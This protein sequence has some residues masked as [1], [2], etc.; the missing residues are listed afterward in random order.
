MAY[1]ALSGNGQEIIKPCMNF[2]IE[3]KKTTTKAG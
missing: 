3:N 2:I 1:F